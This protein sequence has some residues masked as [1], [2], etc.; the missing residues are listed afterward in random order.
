MRVQFLFLKRLGQYELFIDQKGAHL[1]RLRIHDEL[2]GTL[3]K[4]VFFHLDL[5]EIHPSGVLAR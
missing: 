1:L 3:S 4:I 2:L 5:H